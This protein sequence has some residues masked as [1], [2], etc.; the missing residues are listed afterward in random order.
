MGNFGFVFEFSDVFQVKCVN[1]KIASCCNQIP[2]KK[3]RYERPK[4]SSQKKKLKNK[5]QGTK[6]S[7]GQ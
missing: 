1:Q 3:M 5:S 2:G 7:E 4:L 6:K